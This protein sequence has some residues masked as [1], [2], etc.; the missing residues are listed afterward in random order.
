[1]LIIKENTV[2]SYSVMLLLMVMVMIN[3]IIRGLISSEE[4]NKERLLFMQ[5]KC[6]ILLE[7]YIK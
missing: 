6:N 3:V 7:N 5:Q 2:L 4:F 1:M